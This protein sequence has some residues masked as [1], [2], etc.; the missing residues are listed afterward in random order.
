MS[1]AKITANMCVLFDTN[2]IYLQSSEFVWPWRAPPPTTPN[3]PGSC[4]RSTR[5]WPGSWRGRSTSNPTLKPADAANLLFNPPAGSIHPDVIRART[6]QLRQ[7]VEQ[8]CQAALR[9]LDPRP[10]SPPHPGTQGEILSNTQLQQIQDYLRGQQA[11][12][13]DR[14]NQ[15]RTPATTAPPLPAAARPAKLFTLPYC[16]LTGAPFSTTSRE[17]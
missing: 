4:C 12:P 10:T 5:A 13:E 1:L 6:D 17:S 11:L 3:C 16:L 2:R 15:P 8:T 9:G 7:R 14:A